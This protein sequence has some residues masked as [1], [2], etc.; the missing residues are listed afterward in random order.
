MCARVDAAIAS[1]C[2]SRRRG[3]SDSQTSPD[4]GG[5]G[6]RRLHESAASRDDPP[7]FLH[8]HSSDALHGKAFDPAGNSTRCAPDEATRG[9][10]LPG[11][12]LG[13]GCR[14]TL[15]KGTGEMCP[16]CVRSECPDAT[17][18]GLRARLLVP[19]GRGR[20]FSKVANGGSACSYDEACCHNRGGMKA[21][22]PEEHPATTPT[23]QRES[24]WRGPGVPRALP[25]WKYPHKGPDGKRQRTD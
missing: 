11:N 14:A 6:H 10:Q 18:L 1:P 5:R 20:Q 19:T 25:T 3:R 4:G 22:D 9:P 15:P 7:P 2:Y 12:T 13:G 24:A 8:K 16:A 23:S 21:S 17:C